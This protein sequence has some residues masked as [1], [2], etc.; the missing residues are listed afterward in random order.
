MN[1]ECR[2]WPSPSDR[3]DVRRAI[4]K[5]NENFG[6]KRYLLIELLG[7]GI[8]EPFIKWHR[9]GRTAAA[10]KTLCSF[11]IFFILHASL[12]LGKTIH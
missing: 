10:K 4:A 8:L 7:T 2:K 3:V 5:E 11:T 1:Y 6:Y 12:H 9:N